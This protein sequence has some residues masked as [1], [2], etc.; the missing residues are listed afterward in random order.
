M[1]EGQVRWLT[2]KSG[3][4]SEKKCLKELSEDR[5]RHKYNKKYYILL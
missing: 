4:E 2:A 5:E 3:Y 1:S